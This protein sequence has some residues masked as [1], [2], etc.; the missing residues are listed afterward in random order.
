MITIRTLLLC[1]ILIGVALPPALAQQFSREQD[2][3]ELRLG[4]RVLVDDGTCPAGQV[5]EVLGARMTAN[6]V[7]RTSRCVPRQGP[8][9]R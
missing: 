9:R 1:A 2:I 3:G 6:G 5:K 8:K 4:Q 7:V